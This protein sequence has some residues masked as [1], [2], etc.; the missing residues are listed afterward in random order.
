MGLVLEGGNRHQQLFLPAR[1]VAFKKGRMTN[2]G[3]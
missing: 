2:S 1:L 3:R